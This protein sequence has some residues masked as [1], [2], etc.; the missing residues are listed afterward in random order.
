MRIIDC[1]CHVYPH[2]I[3]DKAVRSIG[4]FYDIP[5]DLDGTTETLIK[6]GSKAGITDFLIR[7][8]K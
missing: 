5:M 8:I 6:K 7:F 3:A 4:A 1:H 2:K